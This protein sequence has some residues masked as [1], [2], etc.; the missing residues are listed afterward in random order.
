MRVGF[1]KSGWGLGVPEIDFRRLETME[2]AGTPDYYRTRA[3]CS[4]IAYLKCF[5]GL[6]GISI[7]AKH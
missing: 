1:G 7:L 3:L 6:S 2:G 5:T 4:V